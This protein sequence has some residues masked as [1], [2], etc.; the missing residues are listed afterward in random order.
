M[1]TL[2]PI[3]LLTPRLKLR[4]MNEADA[5]GHFAIHADPEVA[6]YLSR[7]AW[8][9]LAQAREAIGQ[10]LAN[11]ADGTGLRLGVEL[12]D[13][14]R[15]IGNASLFHFFDD[16]RRCDIGYAF[17]RPYWGCGYA[18]EAL[19]A[20]LEYGFG[21]L[22]LNRVEADIDPANAG[23]GR[24]LEKLGFRREGYMPERWIVNGE[25]ADTI[26]YGLLR[27]YWQARG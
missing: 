9:D 20:L 6:R 4:W 8:T 15:L 2:T 3:E 18:S 26:F 11:Y 10:T 19:E 16:S 1:P 12:R 27:S 5:E 14:G 25:P 13:S 7:P 23:S 24:V 17:G 21:T 22:G